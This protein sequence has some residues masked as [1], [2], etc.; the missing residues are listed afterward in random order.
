MQCHRSN[1]DRNSKKSRQIFSAPWHSSKSLRGAALNASD[2]MS[3]RREQEW[4]KNR[5]A[6]AYP[7]PSAV[8]PFKFPDL[9]TCTFLGSRTSLRPRSSLSNCTLPTHCTKRVGGDAD[10]AKSPS[11]Q[12]TRPQVADAE[13]EFQEQL[14]QEREGEI[15]QIEQGITELNQIFKDLGQ[16]VGEQQSMIGSSRS[17]EGISPDHP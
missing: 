2:Y 12:Q 6:C 4:S 17:G 11:R 3:R 5:T 7:T 16:I 9:R 14:I 10:T 1:C 15:E 8:C 13:V